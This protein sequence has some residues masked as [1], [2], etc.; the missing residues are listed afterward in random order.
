[1]IEKSDVQIYTESMLIDL[2]SQH[3][4]RRVEQYLTIVKAF[5]QNF[6]NFLYEPA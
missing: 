6:G 2:N 1:M 5:T 3:N 4:Q